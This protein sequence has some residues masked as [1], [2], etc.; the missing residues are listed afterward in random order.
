MPFFEKD[1]EAM[2]KLAR[3]M[4]QLACRRSGSAVRPVF[5]HYPVSM[6]EK[7]VRDL[8]KELFPF[9]A[10]NRSIYG[11]CSPRIDGPNRPWIVAGLS[12]QAAGTPWLWL[13]SDCVPLVPDWMEIIQD[14]YDAGGEPFAGP[15]L[16]ERGHMNGT[17]VYPAN[18]P[19][20]LPK[21]YEICSHDYTVASAFDLVMKDE[22]ISKCRDL[23]D[24]FQLAWA[25]KDGKLIEDG[26]GDVP[27]FPDDKSLERLRPEAVMFHRCK[28]GSLIDRLWQKDLM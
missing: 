20:L 18:T 13:K 12:M 14:R 2:L 7:R 24:I 16:K 23:S 11:E 8:E 21:T 1:Y 28:D 27:T 10:T 5:L 25:E 4:K 26:A 15:I 9:Y 22:M 6:P 19:V 3:W 17:G